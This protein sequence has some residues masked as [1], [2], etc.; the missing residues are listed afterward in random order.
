MVWG[1]F[2][3]N[4]LG[5]IVFINEII[6]SDKYIAILQEHLLPF[7]DTLIADGITHI[8]FQQDN[9]R[10]HVSKKTHLWLEKV[11]K[12]RGIE[13][14]EWPPYSLDLSSI[15][16]LWSIMKLELHR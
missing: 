4:K 8:I 1:G 10:P 11:L 9:A 15:E 6:N 16:N 2:I 13:L 12:E 3:G 14:M 5:P 7:L